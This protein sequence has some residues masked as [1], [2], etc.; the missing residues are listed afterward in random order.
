[1]LEPRSPQLARAP[2]EAVDEAAGLLALAQERLDPPDLRSDLG[3]RARWIRIQLRQP[4]LRSAELCVCR[5][6]PAAGLV[7]ERPQ[8]ALGRRLAP[9]DLAEARGELE[10]EFL[11]RANHL[12]GAESAR[13][14]LFTLRL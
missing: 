8:L 4:P 13:S 6:R 12:G 10:I 7:E 1:M 11:G 3:E 5:S 9:D 2:F 14:R